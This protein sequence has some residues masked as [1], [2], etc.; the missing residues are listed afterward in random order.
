MNNLNSYTTLRLELGRVSWYIQNLLSAVLGRQI[1]CRTKAEDDSYW[2]TAAIDDTFTTE[3]I[4]KLIAYVGGGT[5]MIRTSVPLD[6]NT[7]AS[8]DMDL[9]RALLKHTLQ[10]D[11]EQEFITKDALWVVG[12]WTKPPKL[13]EVPKDIIFI[14]S[15][16]VDLRNLMPKDAFVE[17]LFSD[18]GTFS[19]F[20]S[21]CERY[22]SEYGTPLYW[23]YPITDGRYNGCYFV[24]V[25]EGVLAIFYDE[26]D[27]QDHEIFIRESV[28][29]CTRE[30]LSFFIGDWNRFAQELSDS[31]SSLRMYLEKKEDAAHG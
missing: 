23:M 5:Q 13:P 28:R 12:T 24:L 7:S 18:G 8:L 30:D 14:D 29:L 31:L 11:W 3:E 6:A 2:S 9:C 15:K 19:D 22:E 16:T 25:R 21:L 10:L 1:T 17:K 20:T 26:I 27:E 4:M